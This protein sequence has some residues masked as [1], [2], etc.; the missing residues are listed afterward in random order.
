[1]S[2][3]TVDKATEC[4]VYLEPGDAA[5]QLDVSV[6]TVRVMVG[7]GLLKPAARTRRGI[8]LFTSHEVERLRRERERRRRAR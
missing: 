4:V 6:A 2:A 8:T 7:G 5:R 3:A 1:M